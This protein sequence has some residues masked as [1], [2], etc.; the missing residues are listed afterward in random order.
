[1]LRVTTVIFL[2]LAFMAQT[3]TQA[4]FVFDYYLNKTGYAKQCENKAR[5]KMHCNGKCQM[6]KKLNAAERNEKQ[7][8]ERKAE[9]KSETVLSSKSFYPALHFAVALP[10]NYYP[11]HDNG[12]TA[13]RP[14][15]HFHPPCC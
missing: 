11:P 7:N 3:F 8:G 1:M 10:A 2:L 12:N 4:F 13:I 6:A 14:R 15:T 9:N 5:P